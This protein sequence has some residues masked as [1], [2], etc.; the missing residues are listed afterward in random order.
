L[1]VEGGHVSASELSELGKLARSRAIPWVLATSTPSPEEEIEALSAGAV[2]YLPVEGESLVARVRL[3]R[4]LKDRYD[5]ASQ[6]RY[7]PTDALTGLPTRRVLLERLEE[8]WGRAE[9]S[10]DELSL[11]MIN[12]KSFKAYNK[13]HG[14]LCGDRCLKEGSKRF[15]R[16]VNHTGNLLVRFS[17]NEFAVLMPATSQEEANSFADR[18]VAAWGP[19]E[20]QNRSAVSEEGLRV[21]E[22]V[23]TIVPHPTNSM[24]DL[25]D[26]A[27]QDLRLR[28]G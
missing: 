8:E 28:R 13:A 5:F 25:I 10:H 4:I 19:G 2:E 16:L 3:E 23:S 26:K 11:I 20:E 7:A 1:V 21:T 18:M 6:K 14:Y 27:H 24:H 15:S 22:G 17:G 12:M 9:R